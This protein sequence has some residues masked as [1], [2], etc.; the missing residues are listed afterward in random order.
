MVCRL[1]R[2]KLVIWKI[3]SVF[4]SSD[5][6]RRFSIVSEFCFGVP[7]KAETIEKVSVVSTGDTLMYGWLPNW[8]MVTL[9]RNYITRLNTN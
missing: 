5:E 8:R 1:F 2:A 7:V 3:K 6:F 9:L 4:S